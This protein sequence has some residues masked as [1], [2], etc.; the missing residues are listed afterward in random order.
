[1]LWWL[2]RRFRRDPRTVVQNHILEMHR[3]KL[4]RYR[5]NAGQRLDE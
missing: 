1:V 4:R 3:W 5:N 2:R